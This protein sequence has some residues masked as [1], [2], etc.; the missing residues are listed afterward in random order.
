M[1]LAQKLSRGL[2]IH[3]VLIIVY[4]RPISGDQDNAPVFPWLG[5]PLEEFWNK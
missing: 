4:S 2:G 1:Y 3:E 5:Q